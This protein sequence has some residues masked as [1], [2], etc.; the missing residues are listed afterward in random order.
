MLVFPRE[1]AMNR[2]KGLG[3]RKDV[4][5]DEQIGVFS[6]YRMPK[7]AL[8]RNRDLRYQIFAGECNALRCDAT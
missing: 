4:G 7:D 6:S 8:S 1:G 3:K 5:C 2:S